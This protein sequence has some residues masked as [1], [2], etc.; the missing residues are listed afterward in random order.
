[1]VCDVDVSGI[2]EETARN[3]GERAGAASKT[4]SSI[5]TFLVSA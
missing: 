4:Y 5:H 1:M 2:G 3:D